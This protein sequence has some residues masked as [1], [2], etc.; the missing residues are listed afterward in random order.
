MSVVNDYLKLEKYNLQQIFEKHA[1]SDDKTS[2]VKPQS[3]AK[4]KEAET[5]EE[6]ET[7]K[8]KEANEEKETSENQ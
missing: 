1:E 6:K 3:N 8:E 2:R 7:I 4:D 5:N